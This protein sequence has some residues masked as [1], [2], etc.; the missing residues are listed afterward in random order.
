MVSVVVCGAG[1]R[2]GG[3]IVTL[4]TK[5]DGTRLVGAVERPGHSLLGKDIGEALGLGTLGITVSD[6]LSKA[7][8]DGDVTIDFT[9]ID[10]AL[11]HIEITMEAGKAIVVGTTGFETSHM[12]KVREWA[13]NGRCLIAP[14]MSVGVNLLFK[15]AYEV[16]SVL[17]EDYDV[18]I[19]EA[20]H[21][22]KKD[23]PSGTAMK[24]GHQVAAALGRDLAQVGVYGRK[25]MVGARSKEEIGMQ[26]IRG[27]DIVGEHTVFFI[28]TGERIELTHRAMSRDNFARGAI[29]AALWLVNQPNGLYDMQDVL[30]LKES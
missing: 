15:L 4:L 19:L 8:N 24:L 22:Q 1:G 26:V 3:R 10:S 5:T 13:K 7:L 12:E 9:H 28:G 2:M 14:N 18:E 16:A 25:G 20:H 30:G 17:G 29:R 27:G 6:D 11:R 23:A 21:N